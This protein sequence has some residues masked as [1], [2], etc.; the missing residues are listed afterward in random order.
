MDASI[1]VVKY[2]TFNFQFFLEVGFKLC[3]YVIHYWLIAVRN[4]I[5]FNNQTLAT[6]KQAK[7][8]ISLVLL[9]AFSF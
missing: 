4:K 1:M 2:G 7:K 8:E 3:I 9:C 6:P 5:K